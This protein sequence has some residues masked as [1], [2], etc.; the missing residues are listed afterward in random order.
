MF[1]RICVLG[2]GG[3]LEPIPRFGAEAPV[4]REIER[5]E[6]MLRRRLRRRFWARFRLRRCCA[7][8][9][10]IG[11]CYGDELLRERSLRHEKAHSQKYTSSEPCENHFVF[12]FLL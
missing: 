8:R 6:F 3:R 1:E 5:A 4:N 11:A 7:E 9:I 2:R 10:R 12:S